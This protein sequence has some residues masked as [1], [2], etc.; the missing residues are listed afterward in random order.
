M[1]VNHSVLVVDD[2]PENLK[3]LSNILKQAGYVVRI[4]M[5]GEQALE[6]IEI[7]PPDLI[8]LDIQLPKMDGYEVCRKIKAIQDYK[9]IPI[10]FISA[11]TEVFNKVLA[12]D[13]GGDDYIPKPFQMEEILARVTTHLKAYQYEKDLLYRTKI[14][15]KELMRTQALLSEAEKL[16]RIGAWEFNPNTKKSFWTD[17][18]YRLLGYAPQEIQDNYL[19]FQEKIVHIDDTMAVE[20]MFRDMIENKKKCEMDFRIIRKDGQTRVF[21]CV[22][23][24]QIDSNGDIARVY[25][26]NI[27]ITD[28]KR[29]EYEKKQVQIQLQQAQKLEALGTLAGG[30]AHDFNN[31]LTAVFGYANLIKGNLSPESKSYDDASEII[32]AAH[33][34]KDLVNQILTFCRRKES[35]LKPIRIDTI[36]R[37]ALKLL[38]S[39]IP[40]TVEIKTDIERVK[41]RV[42][43]DT[44]QIHQIIMNLC[45]NASHAMENS[46]GVLEVSLR[47]QQ[48][49]P[50][51]RADR[52]KKR[53]RRYLELKVK[54]SGCGIPDDIINNIF[55]PYYT[56]K[57]L[58]AG[59]GLGLS[60]V[61][62]IIKT[63]DGEIFVKSKPGTGTTF[64][65]LFPAAETIQELDAE[66]ELRSIVGGNESILL[67]DDEPNILKVGERILKQL[68]Y[69][70]TAVSDGQEAYDFIRQD[71]EKF[72]LLIT[73]TTMPKMDGVTLAREV[74]KIEPD[75]P[76]IICTGYSHLVTKEKCKE[77]GIKALIYKPL[78]LP[79][80][81][82]E[83]RKILDFR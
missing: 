31:I 70:V 33:R 18:M 45:T 28:Q 9:I 13:A 72:H 29:D 77:M 24:P 36:I 35:E 17:N 80:T 6:S 48:V 20:D 1:K 66:N 67:V 62:G 40:T 38:R 65:L 78:S 8:L 30:V 74:L 26:S 56:T 3:V 39:T 5:S 43:A 27:D 42:L 16:G 52:R 34:A 57:N 14:S 54:D 83:I 2:N 49:D 71:P 10:I 63:C 19:F 60:V 53:E 23:A 41:E 79:A 50:S 59:T 82:S 12:F 47:P 81:A 76:I 11:M 15:E 25:G 58:G 55:D 68:G 7:E 73:D 64:T 22:V 51:I 4:A 46:G 69:H 32:I 21:H 61:Q 37:E 44:T 75:F